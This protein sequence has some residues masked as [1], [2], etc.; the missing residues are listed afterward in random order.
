ME[1]CSPPPPL[2]QKHSPFAAAQRATLL[3]METATFLRG[4]GWGHFAKRNGECRLALD[5]DTPLPSLLSSILGMHLF[6]CKFGLKTDSGDTVPD[7]KN[8]DS[9]L[10]AIVTVFQVREVRW[11]LSV[12]S[13]EELPGGRIGGW[14]RWVFAQ[15]QQCSQ[16]FLRPA[17]LHWGSSSTSLCPLLSS[18]AQELYFVK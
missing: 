8:F 7:R 13:T 6:G 4:R 2:R 9:L 14:T 5:Q 12:P 3:F 17:L 11:P 16:R 18:E 10:W 15:I 1:D